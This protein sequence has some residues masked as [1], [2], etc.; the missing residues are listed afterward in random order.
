MRII[1]LHFFTRKAFFQV[2]LLISMAL[3]LSCSA[4]RKNIISKTY[5]NTTARYNAYFYAKNRIEEIRQINWEAHENNYDR[6]L[7]IYPELDS[8][9]AVSYTEQTE[10]A[11][12]KASIAIERHKN[13]RWVDDSYVLVGLA[14][15]YDLDFVN[16]IETFKYVNK[17]SEDDAARH[18][19]LAHLIRTYTDYKE[20][21]NAVTVSD[22][23]DKEKIGKNEQKIVYIN[24]A[25]LY[26]MTGD[27]DNMVKNLVEAAPLLKRKDGKGRIYFIIGQ[28]YA[29]LGFEAEAYSYYKQCIASNPAYELDFM[30]RL[31]MTQVAEI[32]RAS[33]IRSARKVFSKLLKD[34]K[35]KEFLDKIYYEIGEFESRQGNLDL[36]L[37]N[38][39]SS[40]KHGISERQRGMSYLKMGQI[41]YDSLKKYELAQAYYDSTISVLPTDVDNYESILTR[42]KVL[43]EF[44]AQINTIA[45]QDSLLSLAVRDSLEVKA[46][47]VEMIRE[48]NRLEQEKAREIEQR[49]ARRTQSLPL[50][51]R[52]FSVTSWYFDNPAAVAQGQAEFRR[53]WGDR[54]LEDHWRRSSKQVLREY[55]EELPLVDADPAVAELPIASADPEIMFDREA[56]ELMKQIPYSPEAK[57]AALIEIENAYY[58]LGNI[59]NFDLEE[60]MNAVSTFEKL[61]TRFPE[62]EYT[63]E[64]LYQLYLIYEDQDAARMEEYKNRLIN[65]F[66]NTQYARLILNPNYT[67][68]SS[69]ANEK[70]KRAYSEA[71]KYYKQEQ[72]GIALAKADSA[73]LAYPES[74]Y[75]PKVVL[76]KILI[77]GRNDSKETYEQRLNGF[78]EEYPDTD[79][80]AYAR[81]LL[82][83]SET[84]EF[85][86][87]A[88]SST[89][90]KEMDEMHYF[91]VILESNKEVTEEIN[92]SLDLFNTLNYG[93]KK[94]QI[95]NLL[96]ESGRTAILV[97][98]FENGEQAFDYMKKIENN[99]VIDRDW[100]NSKL[101][102]FVIG[103]NNF[104]ILYQTKD[105]QSYLRFF[106]KTYGDGS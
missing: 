60:D 61:L 99:H 57:E 74:I 88:A 53:I 84:F 62:S 13:S 80:T 40:L 51:E 75:A 7:R 45:L 70:L 95:S 28:I 106:N 11:I 59:Y 29:S 98:N 91:I 23:L 82:K 19:A 77:Q 79:V 50:S 65:E 15:Y 33:D 37:E 34:R 81:E 30:A 2:T 58:R 101:I 49:I 10:D 71:Y 87:K 12:Q 9:R 54:P 26:Q 55:N 14:R 97:G 104:D 69:V 41:Y 52:G 96:L 18:E 46:Q 92:E 6:I 76:L 25:Y 89:Y 27:L 24:R 38:Y 17:N 67:Q 85:T 36:A 20:Y 48:Q 64:V 72:Y 83:T 42:Q 94:F 78:I 21:Q 90:I 73:L 3:L 56:S 105:L 100:Q 86:A 63:P 93:T 66:P 1:T 32:E 4:E 43:K 68:E 16:A 31:N 22:Y 103:K 47:F 44:V 5:H 102:N 35:N 39:Q 8:A